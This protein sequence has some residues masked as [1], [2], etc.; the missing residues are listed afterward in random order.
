MDLEIVPKVF[1][2]RYEYSEEDEGIVCV[3]NSFRAANELKLQLEA[4]SLKAKVYIKFFIDVYE[5]LDSFNEHQ[6]SIFEFL[7]LR[8]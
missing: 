1:I 7:T 3:F 2:L 8:V 6:V 4:S 5:V